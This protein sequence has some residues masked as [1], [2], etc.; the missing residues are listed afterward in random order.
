[1]VAVAHRGGSQRG[2]VGTG[3]GLGKALTPPDVEIGRRRQESFLDL[4]GTELRDNRAHHAGVERQRLGDTGQLHFV[5]PDLVLQRSP[6]LA[7]PLDRPVRHGQPGF[8]QDAL[9]GDQVLAETR[10]LAA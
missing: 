3:L 9:R 4:L 8:V 5:G 10:A 6:V 2:E 1:M 7:A